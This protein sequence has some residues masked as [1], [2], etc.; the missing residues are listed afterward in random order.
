M[1]R[2]NGIAVPRRVRWGLVVLERWS[3][4]PLGRDSNRPEG[5]NYALSRC[6]RTSVQRRT[7]SLQM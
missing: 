5:A 3:V 7:H 6:S 1:D 4:L 2:S